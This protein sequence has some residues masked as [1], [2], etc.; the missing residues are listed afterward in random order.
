MKRILILGD[1]NSV[2]VWKWVTAIVENGFQ[3]MVFSLTAPGDSERWNKLGVKVV[4]ANSAGGSKLTYPFAV[5]ALKKVIREFKPDL[6][7]AHYASSY[8][9]LG[10]LANSHP[11]VISVWGSDVYDFPNISFVTK[12]ALKYNFKKSDRILS[13]SHVMAK[14][15]AK[16]TNKKVEITPFGVDTDVFKP[17][18]ALKLFNEDCLVIGIVK[19]LEKKYGIEFLIKAFAIVK[20]QYKSRPV[21]L[22]IVG[23]GSLEAELKTLAKSLGIEKDVFFTGLVEHSKVPSYHNTMDVEVFPS[24]DDSESFGVSVI[25]A[26]ACGRPVVVSNV[27]GLPEVTKDGETGIVVP[28]CEPGKIAT[29]I[30]KL[31]NDEKLRNDMGKKGRERVLELYDWKKSVPIMMN[32][33]NSL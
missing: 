17:M 22:L 3:V 8:G 23:K 28:P 26:S 1:S 5:P 4:T 11:F 12:R 16:Y 9:L 24:V 20:E 30:L 29:A 27:G 15:T 14:E 31:L 33:Y 2:H 19:A 18:P 6:V 7:H 25:E 21:K 32:I 13:T 10:A